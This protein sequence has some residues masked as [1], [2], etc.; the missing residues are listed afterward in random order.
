MAGSKRSLSRG[1]ILIFITKG[2][3]ELCEKTVFSGLPIHFSSQGGK[4]NTGKWEKQVLFTIS[5][6]EK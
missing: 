4:R 2:K 1:R 6:S 5:A 3:A